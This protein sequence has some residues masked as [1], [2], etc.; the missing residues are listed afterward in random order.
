MRRGER[1][2]YIAVG[3][4]AYLRLRGT[5]WM[6]RCRAAGKHWH[7]HCHSDDQNNLIERTIGFMNRVNSPIRACPGSREIT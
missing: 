4:K 2:E 5:G 6:Q 3:S 1:G 7:C